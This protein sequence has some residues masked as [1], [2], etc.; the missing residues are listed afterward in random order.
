[1]HIIYLQKNPNLIK[2]KMKLISIII[3]LH[4]LV[5]CTCFLKRNTKAMIKSKISDEKLKSILIV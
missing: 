5:C 3:S 4:L 2:K 1:M